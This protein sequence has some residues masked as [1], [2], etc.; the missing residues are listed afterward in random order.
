MFSAHLPLPE[1]VQGIPA[2]SIAIPEHEKDSNVSVVVHTWP[3]RKFPMIGHSGRRNDS[4][5]KLVSSPKAVFGL[6][7][8][9]ERSAQFQ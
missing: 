7:M 2:V 8:E 5:T 6:S 1:L 4:Q 3:G 9:Q